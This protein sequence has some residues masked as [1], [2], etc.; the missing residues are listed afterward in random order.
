MKRVLGIGRLF[1]ALFAAAM[2]ACAEPIP[3]P[4]LTLSGLGDPITLSA[5][6]NVEHS[7]GRFQNQD[8]AALVAIAVEAGFLEIEPYPDAG[9]YWRFAVH[10]AVRE[11]DTVTFPV[12]HRDVVRRADWVHED[13][14]EHAQRQAETFGYMIRFDDRFDAPREIGPLA[15]HIVVVRANRASPW[16][17]T[18]RTYLGGRGNRA[19]E[20]DLLHAQA[21]ALGRPL[22]LTL[23]ARIDAAQAAAYASIEETLTRSGR[24]ARG[25]A[26]H[27]LVIPAAG[28]MFWTEPNAPRALTR[29]RAAAFCQDARVERAGRRAYEDWR[30]PTR[31]EFAA[32][33][34][35]DSFIDT[36]DARFW[37][38]IARPPNEGRVVPFF[39]VGREYL[40]QSTG[41][42]LLPRP[43]D[44]DAEDPPP[45]PRRADARVLCVRTIGG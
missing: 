26:Q 42:V 24:I 38:D 27:T 2:S 28:L 39:I 21:V 43:P 9:P 41:E 25:D 36:P 23:A 3:D 7:G 16:R 14:D 44:P 30:L 15:A 20:R 19:T 45:P 11:A 5:Q 32:A 10:D 33:L 34:D 8:N 29:E 18:E 40:L 35:G 22:L 37:G 6:L 13:I 12:A 1:A 31:P 4:T 17:R